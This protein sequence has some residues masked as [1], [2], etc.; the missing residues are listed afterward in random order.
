[1]DR[2]SKEKRSEVMSRI[3]SRDTKPELLVRSGLHKLGFRYRL[4]QRTLPGKPDLVFPKYQ[5]VVFIHGCFWHQHSKCKDGHLPKSRT[6]YWSK[7]LA[8]N[9]SRDRAARKSLQAKHWRVLVVWECE[10]K[11]NLEATLRKI[12]AFLKRS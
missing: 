2:W 8:K 3:R 11:N 10:I 4:H 9:V 1:M 7:K 5:A 12:E 6:E